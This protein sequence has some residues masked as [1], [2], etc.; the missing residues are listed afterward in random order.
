MKQHLCFLVCFTASSVL[1]LGPGCGITDH[2]VP[3][4]VDPPGTN[5]PAI[6]AGTDVYS[7][8]VTARHLTLA[9]EQGLDFSA[10]Q[11]ALIATVE[12][13]AG[14]AVTIEIRDDTWR[15]VRSETLRGD[16]ILVDSALTF[17]HPRHATILAEDFTGTLKVTMRGCGPVPE[18]HAFQFPLEPGNT[19]TYRVSRSGGFDTVVVTICEDSV[20]ANGVRVR[21][22]KVQNGAF[23]EGMFTT[24]LDDTVNFLP[25]PPIVQDFVT[26]H[27]WEFCPRFAFPLRMGKGWKSR[28]YDGGVNYY[29]RRGTIDYRGWA[30]VTDVGPWTFLGRTYPHA[31][32]VDQWEGV[33]DSL[34]T[35]PV[36]L[37]HWLVPGFGTVR[38]EDHQ[39]PFGTWELVRY[40]SPRMVVGE[41]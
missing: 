25:I 31:F 35:S 30:S 23:V 32:R 10:P 5:T 16:T 27:G 15:T 19:W 14:G 26:P 34:W 20:L 9:R 41:P 29:W 1:L 17:R 24:A 7:F 38:I 39:W 3:P 22:W 13:H 4:R 21:P 11:Y 28:A 18:M 37:S 33:S 36:E 2:P 40:R 12:D 8:A 6:N